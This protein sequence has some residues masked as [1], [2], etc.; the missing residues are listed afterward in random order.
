[1]KDGDI[2]IIKLENFFKR[3]YVVS[4]LSPDE[5]TKVGALLVNEETKAVISSGYNGFIRGAHDENL[6]K[7]RPEKYS[8]MIHAEANLLYNCAMHGISTNKCVVICTLSPCVN[9]LR[10]L[11]QC[12]IKTV[13][14]KEKY[15]DFDKNINMLDLKIK[16]EENY[17]IYRINLSPR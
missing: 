16:I 5:Q 2:K 17:G 9:C 12:N 7:T 6:P 15:R 14:F 8:Y 3:A 1:M 13:Y 11:Y 10:S 4:E